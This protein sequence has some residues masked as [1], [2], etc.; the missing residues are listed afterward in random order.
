[1]KTFYQIPHF[2]NIHSHLRLDP[3]R[4]GFDSGFRCH[5][6]TYFCHFSFDEAVLV[7]ILDDI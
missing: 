4:W 6:E 1:M 2:S 7:P 3:R 5:I